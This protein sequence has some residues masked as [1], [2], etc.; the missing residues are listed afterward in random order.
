MSLLP[1]SPRLPYEDPES[2]QFDVKASGRQTLPEIPTPN[3]HALF[4]CASHVAYYVLAAPSPPGVEKYRLPSKRDEHPHWWQS[5]RGFMALLNGHWLELADG[6]MGPSISRGMIPDVLDLES[7]DDEHLVRLDD[8]LS[9]AS[10]EEDADLAVEVRTVKVL[11]RA[12]LHLRHIFA[13]T[14]LPYSSARLAGRAWPGIVSQAY[15]ELLYKREPRALVIMACYCVLLKRM[16]DLWYMFG[17]GAGML[18]NIVKEL[19]GRGGR[20]EEW[21]QWVVSEP[22]K[23]SG[24]E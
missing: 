2:G 11:R 22:V 19:G 15:T 7:V 17:L 13:F 24:T 14:H 12:L 23:I 8:M 21:L 3:I 10:L 9:S 16:D 4:A 20:W 18:N 1:V 5:M 6:P